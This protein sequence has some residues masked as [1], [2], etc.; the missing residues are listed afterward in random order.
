MKTVMIVLLVA[1]LALCSSCSMF[2]K[3]KPEPSTE[4]D[5]SSAAAK[6]EAAKAA[7]AFRKQDITL[8]IKA[9][10]M[11]NRYQN[12][13]HTLYLCMYQL[14]DPNAFN[15][16][17]EEKDGVSRLMEC[18]RFDSSVVNAKRLVI[19]PGQELKDVRDRAEGARYIG[20]VTGYFG[21]SKEKI[22]HLMPLPGKDGKSSG[23]TITIELGP[24]EIGTVT[25][26]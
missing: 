15:Q 1:M 10:P 24:Y 19:Q 2:S 12:N 17:V 14:K 13:A 22:T 7:E 16:L 8:A 18:S 6:A 26:K 5:A 9:D 11:L 3:K 23:T 4:P 20:I 25:S 21:M